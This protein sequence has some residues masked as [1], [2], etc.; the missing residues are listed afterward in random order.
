[1]SLALEEE[2]I[3][4][5]MD[6]MIVVLNYLKGGGKGRKKVLQSKFLYKV[7]S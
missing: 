6:L 4:D 3:Q 7:I 5:I 1:M 2:K